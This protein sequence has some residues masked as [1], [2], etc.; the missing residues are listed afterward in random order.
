MVVSIKLAYSVQRVAYRRGE[1][2]REGKDSIE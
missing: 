1:Q 2:L